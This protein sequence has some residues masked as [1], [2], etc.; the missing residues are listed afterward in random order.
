MTLTEGLLIAIV[1]VLIIFML[2]QQQQPQHT[3]TRAWDCVDRSTGDVTSV[4]MQ[5]A[6]GS[7]HGS[8][9][10]E[11]KALMENAEYFTTA[12]NDRPLYGA[13]E[14]SGT[15]GDFKDFIAGQAIDVQTLSN[16]AEFV[17]DRLG[18]NPQNI[19]G[20][21]YAMGEIESDGGVPWIGIRGRAQALPASA[22]GLSAQVTDFREADYTTKPRFN[23]NSSV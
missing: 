16:H 18:S 4:Q 6:H 13:N 22:T 19:T 7:R 21:T 8:S 5:Y 14:F 2:V 11:E 12:G 15:G 17:K 1:V 20:K 23:W 3:H 10:P 9:S